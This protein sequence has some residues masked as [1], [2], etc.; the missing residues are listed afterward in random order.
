M[1]KL[2]EAVKDGDRRDVLIALRDETAKAIEDT[3]SGRDV[4]A[5]SK[6]LI[7]IIELI[8]AL[9]NAESL[10]PVDQMISEYEDFYN[11]D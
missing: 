6:R 10:D 5:L 8:D 11:D 9:P 1:G 3:T 2:L 7:E 4:A